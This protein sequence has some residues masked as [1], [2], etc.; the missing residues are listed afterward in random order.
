MG[1]LS[2]T[3]RYEAVDHFSKERTFKTLK[4]AQRFAQKWIGE[5]PEL[6][7]WYAVSSDGVGK[8]TCSG[9]TLAALFPKVAQGV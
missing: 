1:T 9:T 2:I 7:S 5:T 8:I 3:V 6:S 4:G